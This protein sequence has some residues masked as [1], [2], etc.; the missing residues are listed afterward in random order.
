MLTPNAPFL[1]PS[2]SLPTFPGFKSTDPKLSFTII[3]NDIATTTAFS[4][5]L[6]ASLAPDSHSSIVFPL[7]VLSFLASSS[8][9][10]QP[11]KYLPIN[12]IVIMF[13]PLAHDLPSQ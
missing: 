10:F 7:F 4:F 3:Q 1:L 5:P 6:A 8:V 2:F 12:L 13:S 11:L 9:A